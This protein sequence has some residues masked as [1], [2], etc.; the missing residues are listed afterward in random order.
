MTNNDPLFSA[1]TGSITTNDNFLLHTKSWLPSGAPRATITFIHGFGEH[2][3]RYN[4]VFP[5]YAS[6]GIL[7]NAFDLIG[8]GRSGG[9]RGYHRSLDHL[10]SDIGL[11]A[12]KADAS[13]PHFIFGHSM[14][15][16]LALIYVERNPGKYTGLIASAPLIKLAVPVPWIK[17]FAGRL[18]SRIIPTFQVPTG[19]NASNISR[20]PEIVASYEKDPLVLT[21]VTASLGKLF[22]EFEGVI[23]DGAS[24]VTEPVLIIH[25]TSDFLTD[26]K[27]SQEFIEKAGSQDK[28][29]KSLEGF[30]HEPHNEPGEIKNEAI[31]I[32]VDW[33][34]AHIPT[35]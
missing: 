32:V 19:L 3:E 15:G 14:G 34:V 35:A 18:V 33:V 13:L 16:A 4:H 11:V 20:D 7:V 25:G 22:L 26:N 12:A 28:T 10:M 31:K 30:Y 6:A 21:S 5:V 9:I 2:I 23:L 29:F 24:G 1:S 27:K 8:H 17:E